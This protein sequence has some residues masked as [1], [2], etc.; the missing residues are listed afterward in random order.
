MEICNV[1][2]KKSLMP[3]KYGDIFLC[4]ICSMKIFSPTWR[5]KE[6][7]SNDEVDKQK[8]KVIKFANASGFSTEV[9]EGIVKFF[10]D[11]KV[12][13]LIKVFHG[14]RGQTLTVCETHC[15]IDTT[16]SFNYKEAEKAY[17][18]LMTP[19]KRG[20]NSSLDMLSSVIGT[21]QTA[22]I[23]GDVVGG[24]LT[25]GSSILKKQI[26]KAGKNI[27]VNA[28][29]KQLNGDNQGGTER[30]PIVLS[31]QSGER[32]VKYNDYDIVKF[33]EPVGEEQ[34]GF[35]KFQ[36]S[37][38]SNDSEEDVLFFFGIGVD[39]KKEAS[40]LYQF[41]KKK[42]NDI[43]EVLKTSIPVNEAPVIMQK[44]PASSIA[45]EILKFKQLLDM[46]AISQ[47][48]YDGKKKQLLGL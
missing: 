28:I 29:T 15:I 47:E 41:I 21:H 39:T 33:I 38:Y 14:N 5:S 19:G 24:V 44:A 17:L 6:Y 32:L 42:V 31:V 46:G 20:G 13:G 43:N 25:G 34:Y 1:C 27:A 35:I 23:L 26:I 22:G 4:K 8:E 12:D 16:G 3:E 10:K 36:N 7:I 2:G 18:K 9:I 45:D 11:K 30:K 40:Q 37:K 48:E